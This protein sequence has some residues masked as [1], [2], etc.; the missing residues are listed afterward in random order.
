MFADLMRTCGPGG[1]GGASGARQ[2]ERG[3]LRELG[4]RLE[5]RVPTLVYSSTREA[6]QSVRQVS[7][8]RLISRQLAGEIWRN[9][10]RAIGY[11]YPF[12]TARLLR[13]RRMKFWGRG[14]PTV[15]IALATDPLERFGAVLRRFLWPDLVLVSSD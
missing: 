6:T 8:H 2:G 1:A 4:R 14:A 3:S 5:E 10:P 12:T 9:R 13:A 15:I 11:V 7:T